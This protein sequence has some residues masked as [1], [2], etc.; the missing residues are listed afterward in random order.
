[1]NRSLMDDLRAAVPE[2]TGTL[3]L[4]GLAHPV[5]ICRDRLGIP[6]IQAHSVHDAFFTQGFVHAQDRLWQMDYDRH[7]AYGRAAEYLGA[8]ALRQDLLLRRLRLAASARADYDAVN[9][10][11]RAMLEAYAAGVN[12]YVQ[13]AT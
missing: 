11:T 6:H 5:E 2:C 3:G 4:R 7:R 9:A 8:S 13:T 10:E 12:A 1:M